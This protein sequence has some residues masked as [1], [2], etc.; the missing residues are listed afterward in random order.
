MAGVKTTQSAIDR[1]AQRV[2]DF[3]D[4][5][6]AEASVHWEEATMDGPQ[7]WVPRGDDPLGF[8]SGTCPGSVFQSGD[9]ARTAFRR[10]LKQQQ[11]A[12]R[13][14]QN[15]DAAAAAP[16]FRHEDL[17]NGGVAPVTFGALPDQLQRA[18]PHGP[19]QQQ[20]QPPGGGAAA[21]GGPVEFTRKQKKRRVQEI[22]LTKRRRE[23]ADVSKGDLVAAAF[24]NDEDDCS[25]LGL[26]WVRSLASVPVTRGTGREEEPSRGKVKLMWMI[27]KQERHIAEG[28]FNYPADTSRGRAA[29]E[30]TVT[31]S[32][33]CLQ[34]LRW[35]PLCCHLTLESCDNFFLVS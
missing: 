16:L 7:R 24:W 34:L 29:H 14:Q 26:A 30:Q 21:G 31:V 5:R 6:T 19:P 9:S 12:Y 8:G 32:S 10:V 35:C 33:D 23:V 18:G 22:K 3:G 20:Q 4:E 13:V 2:N 1:H 27:Q 28:K 25:D 11:D 15:A 17:F